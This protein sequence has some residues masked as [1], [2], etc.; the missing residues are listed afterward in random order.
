MIAAANFSSASWTGG[1][2]HSKSLNLPFDASRRTTAHGRTAT[3]A[4]PPMAATQ[5]PSEFGWPH[6]AGRHSALQGLSK[7]LPL[8]PGRRLA[9][10]AWA[11]SPRS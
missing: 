11:A 10:A 6:L 1:V 5:P 8:R 7:I 2:S 3:L 9:A 4:D